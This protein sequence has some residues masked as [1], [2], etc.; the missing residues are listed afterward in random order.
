MFFNC[1][2]QVL[3][4]LLLHFYPW[5]L[6]NFRRKFMFTWDLFLNK[7]LFSSISFFPSSFLLL[8]FWGSYPGPYANQVLCDCIHSPNPF[9]SNQ[10]RIFS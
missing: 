5:N 7:T 10:E 1:L 2:L 3:D 4:H 6:S 9:S 8:Q